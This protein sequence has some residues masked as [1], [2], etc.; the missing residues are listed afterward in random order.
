MG[1]RLI[2]NI[3]KHGEVIANAYYHWFAYTGSAAAIT[4]EICEIYEDTK[5]LARSDL[6]LAVELLQATGAGLNETEWNRIRNMNSNL[7]NEIELHDCIDRNCGLLAITAEGI[8]ENKSWSEGS[9]YIDIAT[10]EVNFGVVS[11]YY[12]E[13]FKR[14]YEED[15]MPGGWLYEIETVEEDPFE[16]IE[17]STFHEV[18]KFIE[19]HPCG[20]IC[21]DDVYLWIE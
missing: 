4:N 14:E 13:E 17:I 21:G 6:E 7:I 3:T 18:I 9:V 2:V 1:Q 11:Y 10:E 15:L 16:D 8:E 12:I 20:V 5:C 19:D